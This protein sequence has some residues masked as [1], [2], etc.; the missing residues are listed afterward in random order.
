MP[1][2]ASAHPQ[3]KCVTDFSSPSSRFTPLDPVAE[4]ESLITHGRYLEASHAAKDRLKTSGDLRLKQL[5]ALAMSKSGAPEA[6][7][8]FLEPIYKGSD[9]DPE[10]EI[11]RAH[12]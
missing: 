7:R 10:T 6:A 8:D 2:L 11:G 9:P 12:V 4:I 1:T 5:Y 3:Q